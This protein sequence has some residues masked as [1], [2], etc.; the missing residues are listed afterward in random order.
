MSKFIVEI[1]TRGFNQAKRNLADVSQQTRSFSRRA[2]NSA[3]A[4]AVMRKE[5]SM[6]RNNLLLYTF[7][8][9]GTVTAMGSF[10]RAASDATESMDKFKI[11]F[12]DFTPQAEQ[13]AQSIQNSFG[14]AK[15]EMVGLLAGLQDTFVPLG[16]SRE[17]AAE[18]SMAMA[19]LSSNT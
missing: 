13:F 16:F 3:G 5:T 4:L 15:S 18:L 17:Q 7:A 19:Q 6:L 10:I 2:N 1:Q 9:G 12:G 11:V 8:V 14:I